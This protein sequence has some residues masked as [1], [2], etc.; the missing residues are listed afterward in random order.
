MKN[1]RLDLDTHNNCL[2]RCKKHLDLHLRYDEIRI[3]YM[4][5][6]SWLRF[7]TS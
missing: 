4:L 3:F 5:F 7:V 6:K 1:V 2:P